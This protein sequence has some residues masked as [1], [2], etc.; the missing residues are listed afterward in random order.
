MR[1]REFL[2]LTRARPVHDRELLPL[3]GER[4]VHT[5]EFLLLTGERRVRTRE[6]LP[7]TG[8]RRVHDPAR[9]RRDGAFQALRPPRHVQPG[10]SLLAK[11]LPGRTVRIELLILGPLSRIRIDM[12]V[13]IRKANA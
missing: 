12:V 9:R 3:T 7:L 11:G 1:T 6:F 2:P 13:R 4:L 5:P 10:E 8:A